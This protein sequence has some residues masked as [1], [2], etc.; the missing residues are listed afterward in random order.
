M[1]GDDREVIGTEI[2]LGELSVPSQRDWH[3]GT[4]AFPG[5]PRASHGGLRRILF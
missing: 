2:L 5:R 1:W 4:A 3:I